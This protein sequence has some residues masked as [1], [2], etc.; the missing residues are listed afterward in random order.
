MTV[1]YATGKGLAA[2]SCTMG[3]TP[4]ERPHSFTG[5]SRTYS[6]GGWDG[7]LHVVTLSGL[8]ADGTTRYYYSCGGSQEFSFVSPPAAGSLPLTVA[9]V[10]D[11][12]ENCDRLNADGSQG[13]GNAT[14]AA[15][16]AATKKSEF[17]M[18]VHAGDIAYT[19][20]HQ[21]V[22]DAYLREME[23]VAANVPYQVCVG[24]HEHYY[25]FSGYLHR[26]AMPGRR[27]ASRFMATSPDEFEAAR[28]RNHTPPLARAPDN[29]WFSYD[30]GGVHWL[31]YS[32]EHDLQQQIPFIRADLAA[33]AA[34]ARR[35]RTPWI[36]MYGHKPL[37]CSTDA[38]FA[39]EANGF[40]KG[41]G[42]LLEPLLK[43]FG[44]DLF[45]AGHLHNYERTLPVY[46]RELVSMSYNNANATVHVVVGMAGDDEGQTDKW[47]G[48]AQRRV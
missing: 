17:D 46:N 5:T 20:G 36:V 40:Y 26:F 45:L 25:E 28:K 38:G 27:N 23:P 35:K 39:C 9:V 43:E 44:V 13:C 33:A 41:V 15:L 12:G 18:L 6:D 42:P 7:M 1:M 4:G 8:A 32:T 14:I 21:D 30:F 34:P 24:N 48:V 11:L 2:P 22:W 3:T 37:Y 31:A 16:A 19:G 47:Y 10:A 29:L